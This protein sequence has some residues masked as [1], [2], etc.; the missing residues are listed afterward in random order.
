MMIDFKTLKPG[1]TII[2]NGANSAVGQAVI[3]LG[4]LMKINVVN[5]VRK[6]Q[7]QQ[8][9][10]SYLESLG[11]SHIYTEDMLRKS[12]LINDLWKK[13]PRAR[14][15][16]NCVGGKATTD[17]VR[18]LDDDATMV[19]YGGMSLQPIVLNTAGFIFK[20]FKAV[21]FWVTKFKET[22][23]D[24]Y[25]KSISYLC[26]LIA[27]KKFQAPKCLTFQLQDFPQAFKTYSTPFLNSKILFV[28]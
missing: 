3:Q 16:F 21:G 7:N 4:K 20:N 10:N 9:L 6:R 14:L 17:M 27:E 1:D 13:I 18:L 8:E 26:D 23:P 25:K 11:A 2:Q 28:N 12:E 19:T 5:I 22:N 24:E 15:A